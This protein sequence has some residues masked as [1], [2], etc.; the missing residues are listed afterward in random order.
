MPTT[1][2]TGASAAKAGTTAEQQTGPAAYAYAVL[3]SFEQHFV[4]TI[5]IAAASAGQ[6]GTAWEHF[7]W[8][9]DVPDVSM[10]AIAHRSVFG[11]L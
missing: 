2:A 3:P 5:A 6:A 9:L 7:N 10:A 8:E 1:L 11:V 4:E